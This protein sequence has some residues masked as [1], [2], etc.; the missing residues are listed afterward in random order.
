MTALRRSDLPDYCRELERRGTLSAP[1]LT[2]HEWAHV[3]RV[4]LQL[5]H[6]LDPSTLPPSR[7]RQRLGAPAPKRPDRPLRTLKVLQ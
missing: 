6:L 3:E 7:R 1:Y 2:E 5:L 4:L